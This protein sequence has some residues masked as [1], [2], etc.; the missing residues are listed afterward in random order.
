MGTVT[1]IEK[2]RREKE[3]SEYPDEPDIL[4]V[5]ADLETGEADIDWYPEFDD[6]HVLM[7]VDLLKDVLDKVQ[8]RYEEALQEL[9]DKLS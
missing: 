5:V 7:Q 2:R 3:L 1:S 9:G 8:V 4:T 6:L